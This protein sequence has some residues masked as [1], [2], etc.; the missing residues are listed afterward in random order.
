MCKGQSSEQISKLLKS[1]SLMQ[2]GNAHS[3][4]PQPDLA[5]MLQQ[6]C[7]CVVGFIAGGSTGTLAPETELTHC[8]HAVL[9]SQGQQPGPRRHCLNSI[10]QL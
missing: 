9:Q 7:A 1:L 2:K 8:F 10:K 4:H 6:T 3:W 5:N